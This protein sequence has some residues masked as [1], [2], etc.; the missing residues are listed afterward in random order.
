MSDDTALVDQQL[1]HESRT[2]SEARGTSGA[3][4]AVSDSPE[5]ASAQHQRH[6]DTGPPT[7]AATR[8]PRTAESV[9]EF[10]R[11]ESFDL[12]EEALR[13]LLD[14]IIGQADLHNERPAS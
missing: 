8:K 12:P 9:I 4:S 2:A 3:M 13:R 1:A 14:L 6:A 10:V 5:V 11:P 7:T